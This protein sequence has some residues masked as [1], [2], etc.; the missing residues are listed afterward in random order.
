MATR[1]R[2]LIGG[3]VTYVAAISVGYFYNNVHKAVHDQQKGVF[4]DETTRHSTYSNLAK[5]Y[6][7]RTCIF[8]CLSCV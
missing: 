6:D 4:I 7:D 5:H 1:A 2:L 3:T 8:Y